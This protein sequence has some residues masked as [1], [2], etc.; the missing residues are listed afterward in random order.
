MLVTNSPPGIL[1]V[2]Q[3]LDFT[4]CSVTL[5]IWSVTSEDNSR[6]LLQHFYQ[7]NELGSYEVPG[8]EGA[9]SGFEY[10]LKS[11]RVHWSL[12]LIWFGRG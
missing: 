2:G 4:T 7:D 1:H 9:K 5:S 6:K 8:E 12:I 3:A 10:L 11:V